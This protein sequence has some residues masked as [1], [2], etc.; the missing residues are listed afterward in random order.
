MP[1]T[2]DQFQ[3]LY[4]VL[5]GWIAETLTASTARART[6][7]SKNFPRLPLY[8]DGQFL[9][10]AKVVVADT[11]PMPPLSKIGLPQFADFE[12]ADFDA[13]TYLDT[14][15]IRR[16]QANDEGLHFHELIH[17]VQWKVLGPERFLAD[18]AAGLEARGYRDSPLEAMAYEAERRFRNC[19]AFDAEAFVVARLRK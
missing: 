4:P 7:A 17:V 14:F 19:E 2:P 13:I 8:F 3:K 15:F 11:L 9:A 1:I 18:Y 10:S 6:V 12:R 5:F 16:T